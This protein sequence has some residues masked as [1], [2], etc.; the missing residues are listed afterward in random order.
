VVV[1][2]GFVGNVLLKSSEG[3]A[4]MIAAR[5]DSLFNRNLL[6][7]A[8]GALA[9]PLLKRLQTDLAP[10]RHNGA[11][12]LGLRGVVV[13][14]HGSASVS[15]FQSAIY[16]AMTEASENLPQRLNSQLE[17]RFRDDQG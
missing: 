6:S 5:I 14:S 15:G 4:T 7:R 2:D 3:L 12:L 10:A 13:K 17:T 9:L 1:C 16:R 8:I 11:S